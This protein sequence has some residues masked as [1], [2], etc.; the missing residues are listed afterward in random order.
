MSELALEM[1]TEPLIKKTLKPNINTT[2]IPPR[3]NVLTCRSGPYLS[4][5]PSLSYVSTYTLIGG[6]IGAIYGYDIAE[7]KR[8][9]VLITSRYAADL[10]Y[11]YII[12]YGFSGLLVGGITGRLIAWL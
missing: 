10:N 5:I 3:Q 12:C 4:L 6:M 2:N 1:I 8:Y 7:K 11:G 9:N